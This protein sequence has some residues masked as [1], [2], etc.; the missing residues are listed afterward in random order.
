MQQLQE[1]L[2]SLQVLSKIG[3]RFTGAIMRKSREVP[4]ILLADLAQSTADGQEF[5]RRRRA[6]EQ[7]KISSMESGDDLTRWADFVSTH[8][9]TR[10]RRDVQETL[11]IHGG[12]GR[13]W[14]WGG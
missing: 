8:S 10:H 7:S 6:D 9:R 11:V 14:N 1:F 12:F 2:F 3:Q 4:L 5:W 13:G